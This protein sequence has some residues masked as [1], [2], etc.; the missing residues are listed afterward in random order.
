MPSITL[1]DRRIEYTVVRGTG[2]RYT[3]FRFRPDATLEVAIPPRAK[4]TDVESVIRERESWILK[5]HEELSCSDR[6][7][8]AGTVL[9]EGRR[10]RIVFEQ[11]N[12]EESLEPIL[13]SEAVIV[14]GSGRSSI[15]ELVRRWFLKESSAYVARTLPVLA[16]KLGVR[17]RRADV[18]EIKNWGYC[19]RDG[20]LSFSWQLIALP[21]RVREYVLYHELVHLSEHNHATSFKK[22]LSAVLPD[23]R[24]REKELDRV[25]PI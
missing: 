12:G 11:T 21:A 24:Q 19:T 20:R 16:K 4:V 10:L 2:R 15:R 6:V 17:Y 5:H 9:F 18:R 13:Y 8:E 23:Y 3:Y 25:L 22:K 14:K 7:L 1:S